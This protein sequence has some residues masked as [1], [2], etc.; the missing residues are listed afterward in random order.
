[1][2]ELE[3]AV[4]RAWMMQEE[5]RERASALLAELRDD[6]I[7][8]WEK[9]DEEERRLAFGALLDLVLERSRSARFDDPAEMVGW[10]EAGRG[11]AEHLA[12][13]PNGGL[14]VPAIRAL[15]WAELGNAYRV[16]DELDQSEAALAHAWALAKEPGVELRTRLRVLELMAVLLRD[17]RR[18]SEALELL[19]ELER[20]YRQLGDVWELARILVRVGM[21]HAQCHEPK[22]AVLD[23]LRALEVIPAGHG[24]RL[25]AV[26]GLAVALVD[27]G[28]PEAAESIVASNR[29]L[30]RRAG[31]LNSIRLTWLEG[32]IAFALD[33][34][35]RAEDRFT[36]ARLAFFHKQ[37]NFDA[38]L[39]S[40]DLA[41]LLARQ[42]RVQELGFLVKT[43]LATFRRLGIFPE[44]MASLVVLKKA[45]D[46]GASVE[47]LCTHIEVLSQILPELTATAKPVRR[48]AEST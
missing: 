40:L 15:A 36:V 5:E 10:A 13:D 1:M 26:H 6:G 39:V 23:Y 32:K 11:L 17:R 16:A 43:M 45:C 27:A 28:F 9:L 25:Q 4:L 35:R 44:A 33:Q 24:L 20:V 12:L 47:R 38:A 30:Y 3:D 8:G 41:L 42:G 14:G 19:D 22:A 31:R 34:P 18:F 21:T 7:G 46:A 29:G 37:Q 2:A 48:P